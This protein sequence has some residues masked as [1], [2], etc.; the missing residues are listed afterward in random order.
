M[1]KATEKI[2]TYILD[3]MK[4]G[5]APWKKPWTG[6]KAPNQNLFSR[7][8][9]TGTNLLMFWIMGI[10][11]PERLKSPYW[12]TFNQAKKAGGSIKKGSKGLPIVFFKMT[13]IEDRETGEIKDVPFARI[14][15][16]FNAADIDGIEYPQPPQIDFNPVEKCEEIV[17]N[18][19]NRPE[20]VHAGNRAFYRPSAHQI[21]LPGKS[22]FNTVEAYY[23]TLFHELIHSTAKAANRPIDGFG[24][25]EENYSFEELIAEIGSAIL[26]DAA[27]ISSEGLMKNAASYCKGWLEYLESNPEMIIKAAS[28]AQQAADLVLGKILDFTNSKPET[29]DEAA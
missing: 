14:S 7:H 1:S 22:F 17:S 6:Y 2:T 28:K 27:G 29:I 26:C 24:K 8:H 25:N 9:Y 23:A 11:E 3:A 16:V 19:R 10:L 20:I 18:M 15:Y 4:N 21:V 12:A 5:V 13:G